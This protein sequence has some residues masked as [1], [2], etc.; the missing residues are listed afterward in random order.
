MVPFQALIRRLAGAGV[1]ALAALAIAAPGAS[2]DPGLDVSGTSRYVVDTSDE[3]IHGRISFSLTNVTPDR[4]SYY[5]YWDK[6]RLAIPAGSKAVKATSNGSS[7]SVTVKGT[8]DPSVDYADIGF[9]PLRYGNKRS[10]TVTFDAPGAAFRSKNATRV[11]PGYASFWV[12]GVGDKGSTTVEVVAPVSMDLMASDENYQTKTSGKKVTYTWTG[13]TD[14]EDF[15]ALI[16]LRDPSKD[17][18]REVMVGDLSLELQSF[19]GDTKWSSFVAGVVSEGIPSLEGIVG[20]AW[21]GGLKVIREDSSPATVGAEGWFDSSEDEIVLSEALDTDTA[22][23]EL[24]HAWVSGDT[25]SERWMYEGL[26]QVIAERGVKAADEKPY[27]HPS[28]SRSSKSAVPLESWGQTSGWDDPDATLYG[29]N[30]SY[31]VLDGWLGKLDADEFAAVVSAGIR[32]ERAYDPPGSDNHDITTTQRWLDLVEIRGGIDVDK[33]ASTWVLTKDD[34]ALLK[35]RAKAQSAYAEI[36]ETD[37][38]WLPP[39]GLRSAMTGWRFTTA[40]T[41]RDQ[42]GQAPQAA[43]AVQEAAD[44]AGLPVPDAVRSQYENAGSEP[45]YAALVDELTQAQGAIEA[46]GQA[47]AEAMAP[48]D[49][50]T[51][52]GA[53]VVGVGRTADAAITVL[54]AGDT[55]R[56]TELAQDSESRAGWALPVGIG[57]P[58]LIVVLAVGGVLGVRAYRRSHPVPVIDATTDADTPASSQA[59]DAGATEGAETPAAPE[60]PQGETSLGAM[61][62]SPSE[63]PESPEPG[64]TEE[65]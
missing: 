12:D 18:S 3:M 23:H 38:V 49:P 7:L 57:V 47:K 54:E 44:Q 41:I 52:L 8:D 56:A 63:V 17:D 25:F 6:Y 46:V 10:I 55:T 31:H 36:D 40:A 14:G 5:Y 4:G 35:P 39:D 22:L 43:A 61:S 2:A 64:A 48:R 24:A 59:E 27:E 32:G 15:W 37:G 11:G 58:V 30:A 60:V 9:S 53:S 13:T 34:Q 62:A 33:A 26:A 28:V 45:E 51:T 65:E 42:M 50:F 29:Y 21:P 16:S 20:Q 1:V 19:P